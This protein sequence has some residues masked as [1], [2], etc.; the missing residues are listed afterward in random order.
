MVHSVSSVQPYKHSFT[1]L[2]SWVTPHG[3]WKPSAPS[4]AWMVQ[5]DLSAETQASPAIWKTRLFQTT[6]NSWLV[7]LRTLKRQAPFAST[8]QRPDWIAPQHLKWH[9]TLNLDTC[10][11]FENWCACRVRTQKH[12]LPMMDKVGATLLMESSCDCCFCWI[13]SYCDCSVKDVL[14]WDF[15]A[16]TPTLWTT[17]ARRY[18]ASEKMFISRRLQKFQLQAAKKQ[19]WPT[20]WR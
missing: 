9:Q 10:S 20:W 15:H 2:G 19:K 8:R 17:R 11:F 16:S 7:S 1:L 18:T 13:S 14:L 5:Q 3:G 4:S 12:D 6:A